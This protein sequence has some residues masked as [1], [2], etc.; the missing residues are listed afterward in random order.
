[1]SVHFRQLASHV[2]A[3]QK[4]GFLGQQ[5]GE[6]TLA[7]VTTFDRP[8][9][10]RILQQ[11][12]FFAG[13]ASHCGKML[14]LATLGSFRVPSGLPT[15]ISIPLLCAGGLSGVTRFSRLRMRFRP[16]RAAACAERANLETGKRAK[17]SEAVWDTSFVQM[18]PF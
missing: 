10:N 1:M 7:T 4:E 17:P 12:K 8:S 13:F 9:A 18:S 15:V 2:R 14:S 3:P 6:P 11:R 16:C 5:C